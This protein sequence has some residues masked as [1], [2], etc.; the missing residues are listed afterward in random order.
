MIEADLSVAGP[1]MQAFAGAEAVVINQAQ[2][3]GLDR[4]EFVANNITATERIVDAIRAHQVPY[5]VHIS[6]SVVNS[7]AQDFYVETKTA[8]ERFI[9]TVTE[10][11]ILCYGRR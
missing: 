1:W 7:E 6:S 2:I 4:A 5:F 3:G 9:D 8:Q 10:I 11:P